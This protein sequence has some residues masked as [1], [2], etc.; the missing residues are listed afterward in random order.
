VVGLWISSVGG[1]LAA[2]LANPT[3]RVGAVG[4]EESQ[5]H[6]MGEQQ[7]KVDP[8]QSSHDL[9]A[10]ASCEKL[11]DHETTTRLSA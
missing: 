3:S 2:L 1:P 8:M 4:D 6:F 11:N 10:P 5:G 9:K 7:Q